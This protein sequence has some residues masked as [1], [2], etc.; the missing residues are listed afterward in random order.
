MATRK[1]QSNQNKFK[2]SDMIE[3]T[4]PAANVK[5]KEFVPQSS[6]KS[7]AATMSI[8]KNSE[9]KSK[10]RV[11][12]KETAEPVITQLSK[13]HRNTEKGKSVFLP[14]SLVLEVQGIVEKYHN[15]ISAKA[16][17][18]AAVDS[19]LHDYNG[20]KI[21]DKYMDSIGYVA[22]SA[23]ELKARELA[24]KKARELRAAAKKI[25]EEENKD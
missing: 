19:L 11:A 12:T 6:N 24:A 3:V 25:L 5:E 21:V 22:P 18:S 7:D 23:E 8:K 14:T 9:T 4:S 13:W 10:Q 20:E 2:L 1:I 16:I 17:I 15:A